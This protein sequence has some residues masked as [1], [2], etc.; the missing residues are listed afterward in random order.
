[1]SPGLFQESYGVKQISAH[2]SSEKTP[3]LAPSDGNEDHRHDSHEFRTTSRYKKS[4]SSNLLELDYRL[5]PSPS[6]T[7]TANT[8][9]AAKAAGKL[10]FGTATNADQFVNDTAYAETLSDNKLFGAITPANALKWESTEPSRNNFTFTEADQIASFAKGNG[11][12]LRGW[13]LRDTIASGMNSLPAGCRP[14]ISTMRHSP[15]FCKITVVPLSGDTREKFP[16]LHSLFVRNM[17]FKHY[18][19]DSWDV[20]NEPFNDDG[21]QRSFV[22]TDTIGPSYIDIALESARAADPST[23]LYINDFNIEGINAKSTAMFDLVQDLKARGIPIDGIGVQA[24]LIVGQIPSDIQE[25]LERF[26]SLGVEVAITELDIRMTLPV[27]AELLEQQKADYQSV[28]SACDAVE[29]CIG[30]TIWDFDDKYSWVP[31]T[32]PGEGAALPWDEN[33]VRK[34]AYDGIIAGFSY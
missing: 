10:Y 18:P 30:V 29:A 28:V 24:H 20:V 14:V 12:L 3:E 2:M 23:K 33:L 8:N 17:T 15:A 34:P 21:T 27:T 5:S 6:A 9:T 4:H 25:N 31:G 11:Q 32:F 26:A 13:R 16:A 22:F 7:S 1:M 19:V